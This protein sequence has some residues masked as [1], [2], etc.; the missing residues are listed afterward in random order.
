MTELSAQLRHRVH[1][2]L[3]S[4]SAARAAEDDYLVQLRHA[5]LEG[6]ARLA[7]ENNLRIPGLEAYSTD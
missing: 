5:E 3:T 4:L 6:L 2:A 1:E 7:R